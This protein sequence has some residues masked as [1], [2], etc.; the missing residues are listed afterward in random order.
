MLQHI[1]HC[2]LLSSQLRVKRV[3]ESVT[4]QQSTC[5]HVIETMY[6]IIMFRTFGYA[7]KLLLNS[8][9][10]VYICFWIDVRPSKE[11]GIIT[12]NRPFT[13]L[14]ADILSE[15]DN[16]WQRKFCKNNLY[17]WKVQN[18]KFITLQLS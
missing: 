1:R 2:H 17:I 15:L 9:Y 16:K 14:K 7:I 10:R 6:Y 4:Q 3:K 13:Y 11:T 12:T 18:T 5:Q 8:Y